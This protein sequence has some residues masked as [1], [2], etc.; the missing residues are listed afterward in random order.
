MSW[1][2]ALPIIGK[3]IGGP[4]EAVFNK[5]DADGKREFESMMRQLDAGVQERIAQAQINEA[6]AKSPHFLVAF[7][8]PAVAYCCLTAVALILVV[9]PILQYISPERPVP[10]IDDQVLDFAMYVLLGVLGLRSFDKLK[11]FTK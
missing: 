7:W 1:I 3:I 5:L 8:R 11:G 6:E 9:F 10:V 2:S 4:V